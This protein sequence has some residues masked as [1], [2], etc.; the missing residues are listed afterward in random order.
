MSIIGMSD[1]FVS[2]PVLNKLKGVTTA[3]TMALGMHWNGW[4]CYNGL[5]KSLTFEWF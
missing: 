2:Q 1:M 5:I 4:T 3:W